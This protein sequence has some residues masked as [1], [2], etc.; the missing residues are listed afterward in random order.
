MDSSE[1][2]RLVFEA[3][4]NALAN[5]EF[6]AGGNLHQMTAEHIAED[7][8]EFD[9][10]LESVAPYHIQPHV[11]DWMSQQNWLNRHCA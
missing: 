6:S 5:D 2:R 8:A 7:L 10:D 3:L 1:I 11:T 4:K 9:A